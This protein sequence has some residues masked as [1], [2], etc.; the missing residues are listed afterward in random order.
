M[1]RWPLALLVVLASLL[2]PAAAGAS[3]PPPG[4][5]WFETYITAGDGT[6]LHVDVMRPAHLDETVKT[7]VVVTVSPYTN[8]SGDL[9]PN[10]AN[11]GPS[12]RFY[13]FLEHT[14]AI[15]RGYTYVIVDLRG[16]GGSAGCQDWGGPGE[17]ADVEA[18]VEWAATRSWSNGRVG[19]LGKSYDAWT[20]LMGI[21]QQPDGLAAVVAMEPVYSGY[22]YLYSDGVR[23]SNSV[24]TPLL[25]DGISSYPGTA[26]DTPEYQV[27]GARGNV[28]RPGCPALSF[29]EQQ[30]DRHDAPFWRDRDLVAKVRELRPRTPLFLTQGFLEGNTKPDGA[31]DLF[32]AMRGPKRAW[33]GQFEHVR[34]WEDT[35]RDPE[36]FVAELNRFLDRHLKGERVAED[37]P[38]VVQQF[39]GRWREEEAWPPKAARAF[40]TRLRPGTYRDEPQNEGTGGPGVGLWSFSQPLARAAHLTGE[41]VLEARVTSSAPRANLVANVYDV[42]PE[43]HAVM[44]SRNAMLLRNPGAQ[45]AR[46]HLYGQDWVVERG[47]RIGV[48]L[49]GGNNEW[50]VHVPTFTHVRVDAASIALPF[51]RSPRRTFLEGGAS[52]RISRRLESHQES[53]FDLD[54]ETIAEAETAFAVPGS[55]SGRRPNARRRG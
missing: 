48:L 27:N 36:P 52:D 28:E 15:E 21:A 2:V 22:R 23:Y 20:G 33:F 8:H 25:F 32:A 5:N 26:S 16:T 54:A 55:G 41:P 43:G 14:K 45:R 35:G 34:G 49:S 50:W 29:L 7:P 42:D 11:R 53:G 30:E 1:P 4:A 37:A 9:A 38:V 39:D 51:L 31:F 44:I 18:A 6:R 12:H 19:L 24:L 40:E 13:D 17:Q 47:H 10:P 3:G 46:L